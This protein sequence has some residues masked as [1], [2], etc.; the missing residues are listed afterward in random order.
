MPKWPSITAGEAEERAYLTA[1]QLLDSVAAFNEEHP[2]P[3]AE[4]VSERFDYITLDYVAQ[5][6]ASV[7]ARKYRVVPREENI[8]Q[9]ES[10]EPNSPRARSLIGAAGEATSKKIEPAEADSSET[11][12]ELEG[13][14]GELE[15]G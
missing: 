13:T 1:R 4:K 14:Q 3:D 5:T 7:L 10:G 8:P 15:A 11:Q 6:C 2:D 12:G 9:V